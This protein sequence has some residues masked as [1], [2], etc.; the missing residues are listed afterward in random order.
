MI[1]SSKKV[2]KNNVSHRILPIAQ[3][4][5]KGLE[6]EPK[7]SDF[8]IIKEL[9]SGTYGRVFLAE[10]KLTLAKYAIKTI[11]KRIHTSEKGQAYFKREIEIMYRVH[12]PNVVKLF[13]HFEDENFCYFIMEYIEEGNIYSVAPQNSHKLSLKQIASIIKDVISAVYYL[14]HMQPKIIHRDIKPQNVLLNKDLCAKLTDFGWSNYYRQGEFKRL[15][16]CGTLS[17]LAPEIINK[18]GHDEHVDIWCIGVLLFDLIAGYHPFNGYDM[19][20]VRK[21][22]NKLKIKWPK[23]MDHDASD[24]IYKILKYSP[25]ERLSLRQILHHPFFTKFF[26]EAASCLVRPDKNISYRIY[27]ISRDNPLTWNPIFTS[28]DEF[29]IELKPYD[30]TETN[31]TGL[32]DFNNNLPDNYNN[33]KKEF[34][35]Y[36]N[37]DFN[38]YLYGFTEKKQKKNKSLAKTN[39][40]Y[41]FK[42]YKFNSEM[43]NNYNGLI[44]DNFGSKTKL[45]LFETHFKNPSIKDVYYL[46]KNNNNINGYNMTLNYLTTNIE[47]YSQNNDD[48][49]IIMKNN[50]FNINKWKEKERKRRE[51][52]KQRINAL[53]NNYEQI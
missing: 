52:E 4:V 35:Q 13:G 11:D 46:G 19:Q 43:K 32:S 9:G 22:I 3:S 30:Y 45:N 34:N 26:P 7:I 37:S 1:P 53:L 2:I 27:L 49:Y 8:N 41:K 18:E 24:L 17:Y 21:N 50:G 40:D 23:G 29:D 5:L 14:H 12:H 36:D 16:M 47:N 20:T 51:K 31:S 6:P 48:G 44:T 25:E 15:T 28:G 42:N 39:S 33:Q 38:N 10:H